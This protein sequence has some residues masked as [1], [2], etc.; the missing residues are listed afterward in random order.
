MSSKPTRKFYVPTDEEDA[1]IN[2][3]IAADPDTYEMTD[4]EI[5]NLKPYRQTVTLTLPFDVIDGYQ[6]T[7]A[8]WQDRM[9]TVLR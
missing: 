5:A 4:E 7:G 1:A 2:A 6:A 3:G 9:E 8:G